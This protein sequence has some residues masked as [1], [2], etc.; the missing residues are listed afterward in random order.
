MPTYLHVLNAEADS[1]YLSKQISD[2]RRKE[3]HITV[4]L[5]L[6]GMLFII[7][8]RKL[9]QMG[10]RDTLNTV[11]SFIEE[12]TEVSRDLILS[13]N[14]QEEAVDARALLIYLLHEI[15]FYPAQ[16]GALTGICPRCIGPY[17]V[18]F[19]ERKS[20][21]KML[22]IYYERVKRKLRECGEFSPS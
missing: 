1:R 13:G 11:L 21:R 2:R 9:R 12:E 8:A 3:N 16:I 22:R 14:K 18:N 4:L 19:G 17:I 7:A 5:F 10:K 20:S 15:G 6:Y